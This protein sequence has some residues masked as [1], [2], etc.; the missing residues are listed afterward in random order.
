MY[1]P[2]ALCLLAAHVD[3]RALCGTSQLGEEEALRRDACLSR[4]IFGVWEMIYLSCTIVVPSISQV[5]TFRA[6]N[7]H[8]AGAALMIASRSTRFLIALQVMAG[9]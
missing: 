9:M 2:I 4:L 1:D 7:R 3:E 6:C 8:A 5:I